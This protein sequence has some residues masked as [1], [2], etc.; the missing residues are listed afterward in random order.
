MRAELDDVTFQ[1]SNMTI[2]RATPAP[3]GYS[4]LSSFQVSRLEVDAVARS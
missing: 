3:A 1:R 2:T 4:P